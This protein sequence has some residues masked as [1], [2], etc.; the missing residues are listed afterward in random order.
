VPPTRCAKP[1][2]QARL[3]RLQTWMGQ[4]LCADVNADPGFARA[5]QR[6]VGTSDFHGF[7]TIHA[8]HS[9]RLDQVAAPRRCPVTPAHELRC[10]PSVGHNA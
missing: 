10:L 7:L 3:L 6:P 1:E 9:C 8:S 5:D 4:G 2:A